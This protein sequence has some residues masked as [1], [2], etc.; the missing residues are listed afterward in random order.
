MGE[1]VPLYIER[2]I[3]REEG[4]SM[5]TM[6]IDEVVEATGRSKGT[7]YNLITDGVLVRGKSQPLGKRGRPNTRITTESVVAYIKSKNH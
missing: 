1:I 6:S 2:G 4:G 7:V 5:G 3:S